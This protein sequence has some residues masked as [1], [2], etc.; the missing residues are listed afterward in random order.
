MSFIIDILPSPFFSKKSISH[1]KCSLDDLQ[2][3]EEI[4]LCEKDHTAIDIKIDDSYFAFETDKTH[5]QTIFSFLQ[6]QN[7]KEA[8]DDIDLLDFDE[9]DSLLNLM[10]IEELDEMIKKCEVVETV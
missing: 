5:S 1:Q 2:E 10:T 8:E 3:L 7:K 9:I 4:V 6:E